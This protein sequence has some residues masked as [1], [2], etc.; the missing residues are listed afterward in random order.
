[1]NPTNL[2]KNSP[3]NANQIKVEVLP[4]ANHT[5]ISAGWPDFFAHASAQRSGQ[6]R[7]LG[8]GQ[9]LPRH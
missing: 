2:C 1:M 9:I 4:N 7:L 6:A 5:T 8:R 3:L